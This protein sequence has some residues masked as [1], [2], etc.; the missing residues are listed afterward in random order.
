MWWN[1]QKCSFKRNVKKSVMSPLCSVSLILLLTCRH[2]PWFMGRPWIIKSKK[3]SDAELFL[4]KMDWSSPAYRDHTWLYFFFTFFY[5]LHSREISHYLVRFAIVFI[6]QDVNE[7]NSITGST[8]AR[9]AYSTLVKLKTSTPPHNLLSRYIK[10]PS[11]LPI[12]MIKTLVCTNVK[13]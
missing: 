5:S 13:V 7:E 6:S 11:N 4:F 12:N 8:S 3:N 1:I 2:G 10:L 9:A